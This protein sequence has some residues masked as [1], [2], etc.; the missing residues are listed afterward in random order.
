VR[1]RHR[2]QEGHTLLFALVVLVI[3][4]AAASAVGLSLQM[5]MRSSQQE[6]RRV[7]LVA[8]GDAAMAETL[9]ELDRRPSFQGMDERE[10]GGGTIASTVRALSSDRYEVVT[11]AQVRGARRRIVSEVRTTGSIPTVLTW[12]IAS[13]DSAP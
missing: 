10:F 11:T 8:L 6:S 2:H 9:A 3:V 12:K 1:S 5:E 4:G 7:R 13:P